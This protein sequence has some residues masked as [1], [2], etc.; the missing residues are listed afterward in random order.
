ME[1][2]NGVRRA[3]G[4]THSPERR[5]FFV[6]RKR[7]VES[8]SRQSSAAEVIQSHRE[9]SFAATTLLDRGRKSAPE[10]LL[11]RKERKDSKEIFKTLR[12]SRTLREFFPRAYAPRLALI[13]SVPFPPALLAGGQKEK[14]IYDI[15]F[16]VIPLSVG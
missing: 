12:T 7:L 4:I 14:V 9:I 16:V 6:L 1:G 13:V 15:C 10:K 8:G 2:G 5:T 3:N 11:S